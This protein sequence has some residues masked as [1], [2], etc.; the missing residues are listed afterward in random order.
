GNGGQNVFVRLRTWNPGTGTWVLGPQASLHRPGTAGCPAT[1]WCGDPTIADQ[2]GVSELVIDWSQT[3]DSITGLGS[4]NN[5][6]SNPCTG[7]YGIQGESF[8][9]C[10][11]CPQPDDSGP[12]VFSRISEANNAGVIIGNDTNSFASGSPH[13][14]VF[15]FK[16]SG[17]NTAAPADPPTIL[18]FANST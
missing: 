16:L 15:T 13:R 5:Q 10:N 7:S 1:A 9:A 17:L 18:R 8:G 2:S 11:G 14:L 12:I 4:C 3:S 6:S